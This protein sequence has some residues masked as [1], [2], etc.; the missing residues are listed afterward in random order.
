M[1]G[2]DIS[3][4]QVGLQLDKLDIDF[5]ICKATEGVGY[6]DPTF[7]GFVNDCIKQ[8]LCYGFYHFAR[9]NNPENEAQFFYD[10]CKEHFG[11]GIPVL[12]YETT[13]Y[14][15]CEWCEIFIWK[16]HELSG[17][18]PMLYISASRCGEYRNSWISKK[19][20]LWVAGYPKAIADWD[21]GNMP[22]NIY[23]WNSAT[24]WQFTSS[25][26]I[27]GFWE[28]LDGNICY[29]T[30]EEWNALAGNS[31]FESGCNMICLIK[32]DGKDYMVYYDG[33]NL[34]DLDNPDE[35]KAIQEVYKLC[36]NGKE[37]PCFELGSE[38]SP[39]AHRFFDAVKHGHDFE[40]HL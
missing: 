13:N 30:E 19:C 3:N 24:I 25:L 40:Y 7:K 1:R 33:V 39:W 38:E 23:P 36:N 22:Y 6:V 35:M 2:I 10:T 12:D 37:I 16:L 17:I 5:C 9:E 28:R 27:P 11:K 4:W 29:I 31:T 34:H 32:P 14:N 8:N 21:C 18:W 26:I 15:N 20:P